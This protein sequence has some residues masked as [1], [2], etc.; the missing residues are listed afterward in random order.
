MSDNRERVTTLVANYIA[1]EGD[2]ET[3]ASG[4]ISEIATAFANNGET[5]E[6]RGYVE[7]I[8]RTHNSGFARELRNELSANDWSDI[9]WDDVTRQLRD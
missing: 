5:T 1:N 2:T 6:L 8:V 9:D 7:K 4:R 3:N